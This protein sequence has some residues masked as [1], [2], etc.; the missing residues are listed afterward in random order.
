VFRL[1]F[2]ATVTAMG[3]RDYAITPGDEIEDFHG[4]FVQLLEAAF[5]LQAKK[6]PQGQGLGK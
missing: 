3:D 4:S 6:Y 2:E 1:F 5:L